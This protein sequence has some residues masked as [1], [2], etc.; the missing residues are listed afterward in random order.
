MDINKIKGLLNG[1]GIEVSEIIENNK[2]SET[3]IRTKFTQEDGF[4]W[5]TVVPYIDRRAGLEIKTEEELADF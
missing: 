4:S 2:A 5:D 1:T 3:Y